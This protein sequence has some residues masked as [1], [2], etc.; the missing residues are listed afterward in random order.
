MM[1]KNFVNSNVSQ[2]AGASDQ[3]TRKRYVKPM[4]AEVALITD[5]YFLNV[6]MEDIDEGNILAKKRRNENI[7]TMTTPDEGYQ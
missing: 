5:A 1:G 6:S 3:G 7:T 4:S 2:L